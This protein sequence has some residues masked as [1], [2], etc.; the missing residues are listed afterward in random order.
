MSRVV[1]VWKAETGKIE[2]GV[3]HEDDLMDLCLI[4][5]N[6]SK[7]ILIVAYE[8]NAITFFKF[9]KHMNFEIVIRL[10]HIFLECYFIGYKPSMSI[11]K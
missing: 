4:E 2:G 8:K 7:D 5:S 9:D 1:K 6:K 11:I 3:K 10:K